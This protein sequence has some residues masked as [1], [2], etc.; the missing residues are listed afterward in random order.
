MRCAQKND[1][2]YKTCPI[3]DPTNFKCIYCHG[4][5]AACSKS[6]PKIIEAC[7]KLHEAIRYKIGTS[8]IQ[9]FPNYKYTKKFQKYKCIAN[10]DPQPLLQLINDNLGSSLSFEIEQMLFAKSDDQDPNMNKTMEDENEQ[11]NCDVLSSPIKI[12]NFPET[13]GY[14][15]NSKHGNELALFSHYSS[16]STELNEKLFEYATNNF[17]FFIIVGDF[18]AL[19]SNWFCPKSNKKE[20]VLLSTIEILDLFILNNETPTYKRSKNILDLFI[21]SK[22]HKYRKVLRSKPPLNYP[23]LCPKSIDTSVQNLTNDIQEALKIATDRYEIKNF[24]NN[25][26]AVPYHIL[27]LIKFKRKIRRLDQK[28]NNPAQKKLFNYLEQIITILPIIQPKL[29]NYLHSNIRETRLVYLS[30]RKLYA[31][32]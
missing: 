28:H 13:V 24:K 6:C 4:N 14:K 19:N 31:Y 1:H 9:S 2:T 26:L 11:T 12:D 29:Q 27:K 3:K 32:N 16:P 8:S 17:K 15:I 25:K 23:L 10:Q 20:N 18:N 7:N 30:N 22:K 21:C 5:H